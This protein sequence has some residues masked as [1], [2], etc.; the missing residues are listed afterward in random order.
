MYVNFLVRK[1]KQ[2]KPTSPVSATSTMTPWPTADKFLT[3]TNGIKHT[4]ESK[5]TTKM[6]IKTPFQMNK[7]NKIETLDISSR[8]NFFDSPQ[9]KQLVTSTASTDYQMITDES[10]IKRMYTIGDLEKDKSTIPY[11]VYYTE[12]YRDKIKLTRT[13]NNILVNTTEIREMTVHPDIAVPED[14]TT[15]QLKTSTLPTNWNIITRRNQ[16][17]TD[18][19]S[20]ITRDPT[21]N[22]IDEDGYQNG[23]L[24]TTY[25]SASKGYGTY[26]H[27]SEGKKVVKNFTEGLNISPTI[28]SSVGNFNTNGNIYSNDSTDWFESTLTPP[29]NDSI[30]PSK[31]EHV[32]QRE[33]EL[34]KHNYIYPIVIEYNNPIHFDCCIVIIFSLFFL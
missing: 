28:G 2:R 32:M 17:K 30:K 6:K 31:G 27:L 9:V 21:N 13:S 19:I 15:A 5:S 1:R 22:R 33:G 24:S 12:S 23:A 16:F 7:T 10:A 29:E 8:P 11:D 26:E 25:A 34:E 18:R 4:L 14:H 3:T 20:N